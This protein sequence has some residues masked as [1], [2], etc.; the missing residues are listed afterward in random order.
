M[1]VTREE[2]F[3]IDYLTRRY[4]NKSFNELIGNSHDLHVYYKRYLNQQTQSIL[5]NTEKA[6]EAL[7]IV[8]SFR[9]GF[10]QNKEWVDSINTLKES[11][12]NLHKENERLKEKNRVVYEEYLQA[13]QDRTPIALKRIET[14]KQYREILDEL[15]GINAVHI[16]FVLGWAYENSYGEVANK[17]HN[18]VYE[19][20]NKFNKLK[21]HITTQQSKLDRYERIANKINGNH[22]LS[23]VKEIFASTELVKAI[24]ELKSIEE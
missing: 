22:V 20:S 16:M 21:Q 7:E 1:S 9:E 12:T 17:M 23:I 10:V 2:Q 11:L 8:K 18:L 6:L 4:P 19:L 5:T 3:I 15:L 14:I 13:L 24:D